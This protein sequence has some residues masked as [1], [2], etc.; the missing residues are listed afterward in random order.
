MQ[1]RRGGDSGV[2]GALLAGLGLPDLVP[3]DFVVM[4]RLGLNSCRSMAMGGFMASGKG[5]ERKGRVRG[6][7]AA[8][9][10][11]PSSQNS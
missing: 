6:F 3:V 10:Q 7:L 5:V 4:W 8:G 1:R 2:S 9:S 11:K